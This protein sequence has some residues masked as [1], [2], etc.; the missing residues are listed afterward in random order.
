M[1]V[2]IK[3]NLKLY[4]RNRTRIINALLGALIAFIIYV[5]FLQNQLQQAW[6]SAPNVN[7]LLDLWVMGGILSITTVTTTFSTLA[8]YVDDV[9]NN[10][11]ADW[12][13]TKISPFHQTLAYF[14]STVLISLL[15]QIAM[16]LIMIIYFKWQDQLVIDWSNW[17]MFLGITLF[18]TFSA[19][20][21]GQIIARF[22]HT[23]DT[24]SRWSAMIGTLSGFLIATYMPLGALPDFAQRLV[25]LTPS[26][27]AAASYRDLLMQDLMDNENNRPFIS[28]M[29]SY[30][31]LKMTVQHHSL[32]NQDIFLL[33]IGV[34]VAALVILVLIDNQS[35][36]HK[37]RLKNYEC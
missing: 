20:L 29:K 19:T 34:S 30:L 8:R 3:R 14:G 7:Q 23:H 22:I 17:L 36:F 37:R 11:Q 12:K 25:K 27:Y 4:F 18:N 16:F 6:A 33:L 13:L 24:F 21:M 35:Y 10:V 26:A 28:H 9:E 15:L 32:N 2:L 5:S 31:G 1:L